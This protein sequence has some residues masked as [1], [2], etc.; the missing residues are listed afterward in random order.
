MMKAYLHYP[1]IP[2][3]HAQ[4]FRSITAACAAFKITADAVG[5]L[6]QAIEASVHIAKNRSELVEYPD[7]VL[8]VGPRGG[9]KKE[10]A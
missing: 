1:D 6:G 4:V 10:R 5:C 8:S 3:E 2:L 7:Y 9:L